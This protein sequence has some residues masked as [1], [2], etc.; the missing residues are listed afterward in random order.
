MP[1]IFS[2]FNES[3][4]LYSF[5]NLKTSHLFLITLFK[6]ILYKG[7]FSKNKGHVLNSF[8]LMYFFNLLNLACLGQTFFKLIDSFLMH[9]IFIYN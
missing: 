9:N 8:F 3:I 4:L 7:K 1:S 5:C 6:S 2:Q